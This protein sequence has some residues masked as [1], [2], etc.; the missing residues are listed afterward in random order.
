VSGKAVAE[1]QLRAIARAGVDES[2]T[3][4]LLPLIL[5]GLAGVALGIV[6]MRLLQQ[7]P[8][9]VSVQPTDDLQVAPVQT[10]GPVNASRNKMVFG[11]AGLLII[12]ALGVLF[13]RSGEP[14]STSVAETAGAAGGG[15]VA[16]T[17]LDDVDTMISRLEARLKTDPTDGEGF[18][19]LGWSFLNTGKPAEATAAYAQA[20]KL[21]PGRA[22]IHAG[23][24]E[25][26]VAA[27]KD[28]VTPE[29]KAQ[30]EAALAIDP[31][32]A[33][34]RFFTSLHKA[35]NGEERAALDEWITL[36]NSAPADTPWQA[37]V[38]QRITKL[39]AK[40][41]VNV[42]ARLKVAAPAT[43]TGGPDA[44]AVKAAEAMPAT[45]RQSMINGMVEGLAAKLQ[46]NPDDVDGWV[47]LL[48]SRVVLKDVARAK[49]NLSIARKTF[50][51]DTAKLG[52]INALASELGL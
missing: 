38:R 13:F 25:A 47:K 48:R 34:A 41:G 29:A 24:G 36:S 51:A 12:A 50:A 39:A 23:Y 1:R 17:K 52:K 19:T 5:T 20:V 37:D 46:A 8:P 49:D 2:Q 18:R 43:S 16:D 32:E 26:L 21:L 7:S 33:R 6:I 14:S 44:A 9:R 35:Q 15:A 28:T 45:E 27:S 40:L 11:G 3:M 30:F 10:A 42:D 31:K 4:T 22:D